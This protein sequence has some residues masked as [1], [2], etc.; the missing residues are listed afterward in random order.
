MAACNTVCNTVCFTRQK[1]GREFVHIEYQ[2]LLGFKKK[3]KEECVYRE[4]RD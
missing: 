3:P 4:S 1:I 2:F